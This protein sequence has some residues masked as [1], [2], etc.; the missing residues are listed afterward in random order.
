MA[1]RRP[2][3]LADGRVGI[4]VR[5]DTTYPKGE[6]TVEVWTNEGEKPGVAKVKGASV[7]GEV[8]QRTG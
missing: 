1:S 6:E 8:K 4:I 3:R 2:V 5:I 7:L